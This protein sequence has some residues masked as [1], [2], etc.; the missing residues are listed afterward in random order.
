M[1]KEPPS[2]GG[3]KRKDYPRSLVVQRLQ[4]MKPE[5]V[6][7]VT[8]RLYKALWRLKGQ[9]ESKAFKD[10]IKAAAQHRIIL[11]NVD[12][13][14]V[15]SLLHWVYNSELQFLDAEHLCKI[16]S[17]AERLGLHELAENC[18]AKLFT[19]AST[20]IDDA[21]IEGVSLQDLLDGIPA[22]ANDSA[23]GNCDPLTGIVRTVFT[24]VLQQERPPAVLKQLV[25]EAIANSADSGVIETALQMMAS[26]MKD[27]LCMALSYRLSKLKNLLLQQ[28]LSRYSEESSDA[29]VKSEVPC[30]SDAEMKH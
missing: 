21:N 13:D 10:E 17:L 23:H 22:A 12:E 19:A 8:N 20:A 15:G 11:L 25:I 2:N 26:E 29:S 24:F 3:F 7:N 4:L 1:L 9:E 27:E 30:N 18:L 28:K 5:A 14:T 6:L 16:Y